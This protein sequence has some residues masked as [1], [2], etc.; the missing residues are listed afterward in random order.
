MLQYPIELYYNVDDD[1][2]PNKVKCRIQSHCKRNVL[3]MLKQ[4]ATILYNANN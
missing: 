1:D 2:K 4:N 3:Q